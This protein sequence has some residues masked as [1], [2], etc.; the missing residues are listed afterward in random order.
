MSITVYDAL[1]PLWQE[2]QSVLTLAQKQGQ[3]L[4]HLP[5]V[6]FVGRFKTGKS[7]LINALVGA[8]ILPYD[9]D[10]CTG[11]LIELVHWKSKQAYRLLDPN[12]ATTYRLLGFDLDSAQEKPLTP[13]EFHDAVDLTQM[14]DKEKL[15]AANTAFRCYVSSP[16]LHSVRLVDTPGFDGPN[17][18]TRRRAEQAREQAVR[19]SSLCVLV[20]TSP[21]G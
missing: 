15:E 14:S 2:F 12:L 19:Q 21:I 20:I 7:R 10:E 5:R 9:T 4:S 3:S 17:P 18:E 13:K 11:Q 1:A 16:L 8:D 6:C